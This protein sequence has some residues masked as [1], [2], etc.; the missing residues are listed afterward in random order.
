VCP[1][2][3][4]RAFHLAV[5][6]AGTTIF[7]FLR[8]DQI[9]L[10]TNTVEDSKSRVL[11]FFFLTNKTYF[12]NRPILP[13][14]KHPPATYPA[15][16]IGLL[17]HEPGISSLDLSVS[18]ACA[19]VPPPAVCKNRTS[20]SC[21]FQ[22]NGYGRVLSQPH[23]PHIQSL[24]VPTDLNLCRYMSWIPSGFYL[25]YLDSHL[26]FLIKREAYRRNLSGAIPPT[27]AG[28]T[29][30]IGT[31][32]TSLRLPHWKE[33]KELVGSQLNSTGPSKEIHPS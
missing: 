20:T 27:P 4:D 32:G 15:R 14:P 11:H 22:K 12:S 21:R 19:T 29:A 18:D 13:R 30:R 25:S 17:L 24:P 5:A 2:T 8:L 16:C 6:R 1:V 10:S 33:S 7:L 31:D 28:T 3:P 9:N 26:T 23:Q